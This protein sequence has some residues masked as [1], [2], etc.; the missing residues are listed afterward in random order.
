VIYEEE[1]K[2][3]YSPLR[4]VVRKSVEKYLECGILENGLACIVC[5]TSKAE[6]LM[7]FSCKIRMLCPN[8]SFLATFLENPICG[9]YIGISRVPVPPA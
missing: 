5:G 1:Y 4:M 9:L 2:Q 7:G 8:S 6:F 3:Q